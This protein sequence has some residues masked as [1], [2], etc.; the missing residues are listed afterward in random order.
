MT[1][2]GGGCIGARDTSEH[3]RKKSVAVEGGLVILQGMLSGGT[4]LKVE[5][6][7][8]GQSTIGRIS[9]VE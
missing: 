2:Y 4:W 8:R 9:E 6:G 1:Q 7:A 5:P 3:V